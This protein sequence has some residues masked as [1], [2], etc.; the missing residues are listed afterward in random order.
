MRFLQR[1]VRPGDMDGAIATED[2]KRLCTELNVHCDDA[3]FAAVA[4]ACPAPGDDGSQFLSLRAVSVRLANPDAPPEPSPLTGTATA[5]VTLDQHVRAKRHQAWNAYP[6]EPVR[7]FPTPKRP[8][9][10]DPN[11]AGEQERSTC[12][13]CHCGRTALVAWARA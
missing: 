11:L 1:Y 13:V 2:Y 7:P 6:E 10:A 3:S 12:T 9:A 8:T 5:R 4:A